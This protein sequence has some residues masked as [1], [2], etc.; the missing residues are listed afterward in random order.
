MSWGL[1]PRFAVVARPTV[2]AARSGLEWLDTETGHLSPLLSSESALSYPSVSA[3]GSRVAYTIGDID[4]D[5]VESL[6]T[7]LPFVLS[8][9]RVF[10][11]TRSITRRG[12]RVRVHAR[13]AEGRFVSGSRHAGRTGCRVSVGFSRPEGSVEICRRRFSPDGTKLAYNRNFTSGSRRRTAALPQSSPPRRPESL[14]PNGPRMAPGS[15]S[16]T[17][18]LSSRAWSRFA[19]ALVNPRSGY[20]WALRSGR[21][22]MVA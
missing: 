20:G 3:D 17:R 9:P 13:P 4:Y 7:D 21:A 14:Q 6:W 19:S 16:I 10:P 11:N 8:S 22:S 2:T 5:L 18:D 1:D 15:P 12:P